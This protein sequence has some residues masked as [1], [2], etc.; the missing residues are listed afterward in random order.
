[1]IN[2]LPHRRKGALHGNLDERREVIG[3]TKYG[4]LQL[5]YIT[6]F[7]L[8]ILP[9]WPRRTVVPLLSESMAHGDWRT[10]MSIYKDV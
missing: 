4:I 10:D 7:R 3:E 5:V 6:Y 8:V 9:S 1:M 2:V